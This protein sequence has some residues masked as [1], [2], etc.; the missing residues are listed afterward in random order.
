M[1]FT[2]TYRAKDG[3]LREERID[4]ANRAECVA[5]CRRR[6]ISPVGIREGGKSKGRDGARPSHVGAGDNK[7]TTA[8]WVAAAVVVAMIAGGAWWWISARSAS[9]PYQAPAKPKVEKPKGRD[10]ERPSQRPL[11]PRKETP[12]A[13]GNGTAPATNDVRYY[14]GQPVVRVDATTNGAGMLVERLYTADGK[15]HR[16]THFPP[17]VFKHA[18]DEYL[19]TLLSTPSG[20]ETPPFPDLSRE[21]MEEQFRKSLEDEIEIKPD[22]PERIRDLKAKVMIVR[23]NMKELLKEGR[24]FAEVLEEARKT[25]NENVEVRSQAVAQYYELLRKGQAGDAEE[26]RKKMNEVLVQMG[27]EEISPRQ[28]ARGKGK[29]GEKKE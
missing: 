14:A 1:T 23:E 16:V 8:R 3:A 25:A 4:A 29:T 24:G 18:S 21:N 7:R 9:V 11:S 27:I 17:P 12:K 19:A 20:A 5:E 2:V 26:L 15:R 6:G 10:G 22:D 28:S 13:A